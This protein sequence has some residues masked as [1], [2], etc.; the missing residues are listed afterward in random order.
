MSVW[1][2]SEMDVGILSSYTFSKRCLNNSI[3]VKLLF[4]QFV[5]KLWRF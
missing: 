4:F 5:M 1:S 2:Q 3:F